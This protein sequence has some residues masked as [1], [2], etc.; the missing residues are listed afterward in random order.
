MQ[1]QQANQPFDKEESFFGGLLKKRTRKPKANTRG[2]TGNLAAAGA[3]SAGRAARAGK[4]TKRF[5]K[6]TEDLGAANMRMNAAQKKAA[7]KR[8]KSE[9]GKSDRPSAASMRASA[10]QRAALAKSEPK[11]EPKPA[12]KAKVTGGG[13]TKKDRNVGKGASKRA[14]VTAEQLKAAG[15][16]GGPKGLR[17]YL[18]MFDK[19]GRRPKPSDFKKAAPKKAAP[20]GRSFDATKP[21]QGGPGMASIKPPK[22]PMSPMAAAAKLSA[23]GEDE[24]PIKRKGG[25]MMKTKGYKAGGK[26]KAKGMAKGGST[27]SVSKVKGPIAVDTSA[28]SKKKSIQLSKGGKLPEVKDPKAGKMIPA[29]AADGKGKM[30]SGGPVKKMKTKGYAKGGMMKSK[31][32]AKGGKVRGAGIA[33]KGVRPAK[34]R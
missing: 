22:G 16:T 12:K 8:V 32:Y 25:G 13:E 28:I 24:M 30:M 21:N 2:A 23:K 6:D 27:S 26:M 19:L 34:M 29:Y 33:R 3:A 15:L 1:G 7:N 11:K 9:D 20:S 17:T 4:A 10:A 31:G 14:N 5:A 18:N